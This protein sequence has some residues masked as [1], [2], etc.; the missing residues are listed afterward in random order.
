VDSRVWIAG[1]YGADIPS[2]S[3]YNSYKTWVAEILVDTSV[4]VSTPM[5]EKNVSIFPN[6]VY[7]ILQMEFVIDHPVEISI[8]IYDTH[9]RLVK[10]LYRDVPKSGLNRLTFNKG[11][12]SPGTYYVHVRTDHHVMLTE[13]I[14]VAK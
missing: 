13:K 3:T 14:I 10:L 6:P 5:Q 1:S 7:D 12:L 11:A 2:Q 9:G 8:T 4:R